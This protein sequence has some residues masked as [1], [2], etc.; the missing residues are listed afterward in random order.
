MGLCQGTEFKGRGGASQ[1]TPDLSSGI[2]RDHGILGG[3]TGRGQAP[4]GASAFVVRPRTLPA[5]P[6]SG[7][8]EEAP[9]KTQSGQIFYFIFKKQ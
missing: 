5:V 2:C 8:W 1:G 9:E 4:R 3:N 6:W 7:V